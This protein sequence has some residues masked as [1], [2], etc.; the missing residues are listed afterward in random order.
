MLNGNNIL[1]GVTG[2]IACYKACE[3]VS[4]LKKLGAC[5]DVIMTKN[6]TEFVSPLSFETLSQSP[7]VV[8]MF[9]P[10]EHFEVEH[11]SLAKK[12]DLC[13]IAPATA[14]AIAKL[15]NGIADDMLSTTLLATKAPIIVAPAMNT[16]MYDNVAT[17]RNIATLKSRGVIFVE[18]NEGRLA[19]G[20]VGK[21]KLAEPIQ[22]VEKAIDT[23][24][25][26]QDYVGKNVLITAGGT[27]ESIDGVRFITNRSSGKMG[28]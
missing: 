27:Q 15:A 24:L 7:V 23:L 26:C 13:I 22:I 11:I 3:I 25:P 9:A 17:R 28:L 19:C 1:L 16:A 10:I 21:G 5:V 20:D 14:N 18:P 12:A 8:D 4:R 6:A 2:G